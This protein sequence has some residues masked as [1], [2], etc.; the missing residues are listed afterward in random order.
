MQKWYA[1]LE[2]KL[3]L[4]VGQHRIANWIVGFFINLSLSCVDW[5]T[6]SLLEL[7]LFAS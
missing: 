6:C 1:D 2:A 5:I 7:L 4:M 3:D